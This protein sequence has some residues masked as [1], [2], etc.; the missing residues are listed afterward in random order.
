[1]R[2]ESDFD[3]HNMTAK[4]KRLTMTYIKNAEIKHIFIVKFALSNA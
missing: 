2:K 1:M 4:C 3:K